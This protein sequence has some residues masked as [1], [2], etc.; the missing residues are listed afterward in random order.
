MKKHGVSIWY[1]LPLLRLLGTTILCAGMLNV[2]AVCYAQNLGTAPAVGQAVQGQSASQPEGAFLNLVNWIG[3]VICPVGAALAVVGAVLSWRQGR[4]YM[5]WALTAG[6]L[7]AVS[8]LTRLLEYFI[9]NG[10][11]IG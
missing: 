7:L 11:A 6:G 2:A 8:G 3:N 10:Q 5:P 1:S 9:Q 4:G